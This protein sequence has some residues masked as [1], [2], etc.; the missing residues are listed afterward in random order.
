[1]GQQ[2][3]WIIPKDDYHESFSDNYNE[4]MYF[5]TNYYD[6]SYGEF[7]YVDFQNKTTHPISGDLYHAQN[8]G[9]D[10]YL[11]GNKNLY[12]KN[13]LCNLNFSEITE[14]GGAR[15]NYASYCNYNN[16]DCFWL[17]LTSS[18]GVK[19]N[20][21]V[22][23]EGN[24]LIQ[25]TKSYETI[26]GEKDGWNTKYTGFTY[27]SNLCIAKD[28]ESGLYGY[29][30]LDG[31]W[32]IQPIYNSASNFFGDDDNAVAV[33]NNSIIINRQGEI[34]YTFKDTPIE[35]V[36][37]LNGTYKYTISGAGGSYYLI[38]TEDGNLTIENIM[39]GGWFSKDGKYDIKGGKL[40][41]SDFGSF[42]LALFPIVTSDG[43]YSFRKE[44]DSIFIE[45]TEW[46]LVE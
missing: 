14:F 31:E 6:G 42:T 23:I 4:N 40:I 41:I 37:N 32:E 22:D 39:S 10:Y 9:G 28:T 27:N 16:K 7:L 19:F 38:F 3:D 13:T 26:I 33:V 20:A 46:I 2:Q 45:D 44:G 8:I 29:I 30:N 25:P 12:Y 5:Y 35:L 15:I 1:M 24:I 36:D 18:S 21:L 17:K 34:I 43:T 11:D